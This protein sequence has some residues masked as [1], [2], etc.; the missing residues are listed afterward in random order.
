ME[1][2][3]TRHEGGAT[4]STGRLAA[5]VDLKQ[6]AIRGK[7]KANMGCLVKRSQFLRGRN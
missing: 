7:R 2:N 3:G 1:G 6:N 4:G 5:K